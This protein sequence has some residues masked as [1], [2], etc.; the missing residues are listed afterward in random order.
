MRKHYKKGC[1]QFDASMLWYLDTRLVPPVLCVQINISASK[2]L[3]PTLKHS[4]VS[5]TQRPERAHGEELLQEVKSRSNT[6]DTNWLARL[7]AHSDDLGNRILIGRVVV[8]ARNAHILTYI[9]LEPMGMPSTPST[10]RHLSTSSTAAGDSIM[11][12]SIVSRFRISFCL[13]V[14]TF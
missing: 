3:H 14:G 13:S 10:A 11:G 12:I 8:L 6:T 7:L 9:S 4:Y 2:F 1:Y 5:T